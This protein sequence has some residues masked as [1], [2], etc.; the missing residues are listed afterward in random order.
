MSADLC[1]TRQV[2]ALEADVGHLKE[3]QERQGE[4]LERLEARLEQILMWLLGLMGGM[5]VSLI[6]LLFNLMAGKG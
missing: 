5:A 6:L 2:C 4:A 1:L 3:W